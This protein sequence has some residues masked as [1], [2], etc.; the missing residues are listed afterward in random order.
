MLTDLHKLKALGKDVKIYPLAKIV[1]PE[2]VE[3]G[4]GTQIDDF[5]FIYGGQGV[6][7][8]R[9]NHFASFIS[10]IGGGEFITEDY[11]GIATGCRLITGTHHYGEGQRI[12][13]LIPPEEQCVIRG[14]IVLKKDVFLGANVIVHPNVTIGEGAIVGSGG[15]VLKD[16]EP[17]TINVGAPVRVVGTRPRVREK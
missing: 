10:V 3:I 1:K 9:L 6:K 14:K 8:G 4:D 2:V 15:I 13:P 11:V 7:I 17:W 5:I 12:S 16:I